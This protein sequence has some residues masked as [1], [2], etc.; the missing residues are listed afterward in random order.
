MKRSFIDARIEAMLSRL[1]AHGSAC[2][3]SPCGARTIIAPTLPPRGASPKAGSAGTSSSSSPA[4][5][6]TRW[7][8]RVH[9]AHGR[10]APTSA[11][12]RGRLYAEKALF[13][14]DGQRTPH[15]YHIVKTE[16][17]VNRGGAPLRRRTVQ[18]RPRRRAAQRALPRAEGRQDARPR[19]RRRVTLEPG[20]SLTLEPF[21]AHAFWAEGGATLAGEV[22]L[23]NDDAQ[24]QLLPARR[25]P[26]PAPIEEDRPK[27]YVTVRDHR[28]SSRSPV[29]AARAA[30]TRST[31][32]QPLHRGEK[33]GDETRRLDLD[34]D[35]G[36]GRPTPD[37]AP[38]GDRHARWSAR[39]RLDVDC[40]ALGR[41][42]ATDRSPPRRR[43]DR[44]S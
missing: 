44:A 14:E 28:A 16:D 32:R 35:M 38:I 17:I 18:G 15:H 10:L 23:V 9:A 11:D 43:A 40:G 34:R 12:G 36:V 41:R 1:R 29:R 19:A 27:R 22:S 7:P 24:R 39:P 31:A 26:P 25:F 2:R 6:R 4:P 33:F 30:A 37:A 13:A 20:E 3:L 5:S 42:S 21:V 8:Q